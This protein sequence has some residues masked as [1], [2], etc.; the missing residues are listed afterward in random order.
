MSVARFTVSGFSCRRPRNWP[1]LVVDEPQLPVTSEVTP[2]RT[3]LSAV[4]VL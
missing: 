3:K 4:G 1:T 2:M